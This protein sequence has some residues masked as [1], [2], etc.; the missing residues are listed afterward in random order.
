[1]VLPGKVWKFGRTKMGAWQDKMREIGKTEKEN[2]A[3]DNL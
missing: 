3:K 1:M 2:V